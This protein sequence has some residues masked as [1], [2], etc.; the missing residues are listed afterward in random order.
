MEK[1]AKKEKEFNLLLPV[2][3]LFC[4][5]HLSK[6]ILSNG[7][8]SSHQL[9]IAP[10]CSLGGTSISWAVS[11]HQRP[12]AGFFRETPLVSEISATPL[13]YLFLRYLNPDP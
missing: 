6:G 7:N 5:H 11:L 12:Q 8:S 1:I 10:L 3:L 13:L 4:L 9:D 2:A